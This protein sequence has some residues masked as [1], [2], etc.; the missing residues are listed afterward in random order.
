VYWRLQLLETRFFINIK[1]NPSSSQAGSG[2]GSYVMM[3][4]HQ[5]AMYVEVVTKYCMESLTAH[6][7]NL[8]LDRLEPLPRWWDLRHGDL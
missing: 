6:T 7:S 5:A 2:L 8:G 4:A 3:S 1:Q